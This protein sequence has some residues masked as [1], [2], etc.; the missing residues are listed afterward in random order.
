MTEPS[1][2][3]TVRITKETMSDPQFQ[4]PQRPSYGQ[5]DTVG[6]APTPAPSVLTLGMFN[7]GGVGS[8]STSK[9]VPT[10]DL[11]TFPQWKNSQGKRHIGWFFLGAKAGCK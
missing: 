7:M 11:V 8:N 1:Y 5:Q 2:A 4:V 9:F 6:P 10:A 3:K